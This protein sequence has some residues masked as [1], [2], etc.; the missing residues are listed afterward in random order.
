MFRPDKFMCS[1]R[2]GPLNGFDVMIM[3]S[4]QWTQEIIKK[5]KQRILN[6]ENPNECQD[7]IF[8]EIGVDFDKDIVQYDQERIIKEVE[9]MYRLNELGLLHW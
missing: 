7:E 4:D 5:F 6:G 1:V 8:A 3:Q 2:G 9:E